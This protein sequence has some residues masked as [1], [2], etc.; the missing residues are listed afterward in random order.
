MNR[1]VTIIRSIAFGATLAAGLVSAQAQ[2]I[3]TLGQPA[4]QSDLQKALSAPIVPSHLA[5]A[6]DVLKASGMRAMFVNSLPNVVGALRVNVTRQRPELTKEIEEVLKLVEANSEKVVD[7]GL[8]GAARF[9]A[10][11]MNEAELKEV[12]TFMTSTVGKKYV[13]TL[14]GFM[15][16]VLP[17][18][19]IWS[20]EAGQQLA[21]FFQAEMLKRGHKL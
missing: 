17:Y 6:T 2:Q 21:G 7:E 13:E 14:P 5:L 9:M 8:T 16:Q 3:P 20:E 1:L 18:L 12:L 10:L 15:D 19:Q 11:R 4:P